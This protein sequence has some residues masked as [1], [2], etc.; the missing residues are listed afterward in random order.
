VESNLHPQYV[1][2]ARCLVKHKNNFIFTNIERLNHSID[3]G[4]KQVDGHAISELPVLYTSL[5]RIKFYPVLLTE[6]HAIKAYWG[7]ED[8]APL[9][10]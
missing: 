10:L 5:I 3:L 1:F 7:S 4:M 6:H 8:I 2:M 9:I